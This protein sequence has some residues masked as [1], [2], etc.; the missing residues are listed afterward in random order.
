[1]LLLYIT[2]GLVSAQ[3]RAGYVIDAL[4][5]SV[6]VIVLFDFFIKVKFVILSING[7]LKVIHVD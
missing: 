3:A 2:R 7:E 1:M 4:C 5:C 6:H